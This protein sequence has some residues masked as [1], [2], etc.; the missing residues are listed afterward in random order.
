M[1]MTS[2]TLLQQGQL[3][4]VFSGTW[5]GISCMSMPVN[6]FLE[7]INLVK[8]HKEGHTSYFSIDLLWFPY[9]GGEENNLNMRFLKPERTDGRSDLNRGG[10]VIGDTRAYTLRL[11]FPLPGGSGE[12]KTYLFQRPG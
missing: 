8:L 10:T 9:T 1:G 5:P 7:L 3:L 6:I 4:A 2:R 12:L 11:S